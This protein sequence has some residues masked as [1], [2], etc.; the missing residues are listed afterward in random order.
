MKKGLQQAFACEQHVA[1]IIAQQETNGVL[2]NEQ[3]ARFYIHVLEERKRKLY[4]RIRPYLEMEVVRPYD[5]EV[6]KP[7]K[8]DGTHSA[9]VER[10]FDGDTANVSG[11]FSRVTFVEPNLGSRVKLIA[12]LLRLGWR[13]A[14]FTEKGNPKLTVDGEPCESLL[15]IGTEVGQWIADWYIF[16]HRESQIKGWLRKL[17]PDGRLTAEAITCG[18]PTYRM[19]HKVVVNVP[20]AKKH[21]PFGREMRS[22]FTVPKGKVL[23][24]HDAS[25]L[26]LRMLAHYMGD[27]A[28]IITV[29]EGK[30]EDGTDVHTVNQR[31][32]GLP[33]RDDGKTFIYAFNYGAGDPKLGSIIG[34]TARDG[35]LMRARFL[36]ANESLALLIERVQKAGERGWLM[37]LDGRKIYLRVDPDTKKPQVHKALNTLLQ[38]AGAV[39]M[40]YS[41]IFLDKWVREE[42]LDVKKVIDMHDEAQAEVA[43][44]HA[45]RYGELAVKSVRM[46]GK[47]LNLA[48]PLDASYKIGRNWAQTH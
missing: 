14:N 19:R 28:Y 37:G 33:T 8:K 11:P 4:L 30:E 48:C 32:A 35:A 1:R 15:Q 26:E 27:P 3:K 42:G 41:M 43:P 2:F 12:Q 7:F 29:C 16:N 6:Q 24:G 20:K 5:K 23:V 18:T 34:G 31:M 39:V 36:A 47:Y 25:G 44:E 21:V 13:P 9:I 17:R 45:H 10:W 38:T 22:L 46:A 40:K